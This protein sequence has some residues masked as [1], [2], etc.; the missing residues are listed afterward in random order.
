MKQLY[1][2]HASLKYWNAICI[3]KKKY[4]VVLEWCF[5][6]D[7]RGRPQSRPVVITIFTQSVRTSI[8]CPSQ[9]FK[10][11]RPSLLSGTVGWPSGSLMTPVLFFNYFS[12]S[13]IIDPLGQPP[14]TANSFTWKLV[15]LWVWPIGSWIRPA[16][17][18]F[19]FSV[20][21]WWCFVGQTPEFQIREL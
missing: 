16:L 10:I 13:P 21:Q 7:P 15:E 19:R 4:S 20:Q 17:Y 2:W 12:N 1:G 5:I 6:I 18:F 14:V 8:V 9:N 11:K 3:V